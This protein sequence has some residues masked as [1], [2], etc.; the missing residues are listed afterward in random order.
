MDLPYHRVLLAEWIEPQQPGADYDLSRSKAVVPRH[1]KTVAEDMIPT[2]PSQ[3]VVHP[4]VPSWQRLEW[5]QKP[6]SPT[7]PSSASHVY[8]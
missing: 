8:V 4:V 3:S 5:L 6:T 7:F 1:L 2:A